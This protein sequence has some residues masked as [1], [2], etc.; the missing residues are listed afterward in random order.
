MPEGIIQFLPLV[1]IF[2]VMYFLILRPQSKKQKEHQDMI[3]AIKK[4][5]RIVTNGGLI[6]NISQILDKELQLEIA[7][8]VRVRV[9]RSMV[10]TVFSGTSVN[11]T[12]APKTQNAD[13]VKKE[14]TSIIKHSKASTKAKGKKTAVVK[15]K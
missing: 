8:G 2:G 9:L 12:T 14:S 4:G 7:D 10:A 5:D 1:L 3:N 13:S 15:K 6:G 11:E